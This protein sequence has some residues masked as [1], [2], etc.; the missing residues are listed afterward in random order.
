[1]VGFKLEL[2]GIALPSV[3]AYFECQ[4]SPWAAAAFRTLMGDVNIQIVSNTQM[5]RKN[6]RGRLV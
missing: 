1:M 5:P 6:L 2:S 3:F 4:E